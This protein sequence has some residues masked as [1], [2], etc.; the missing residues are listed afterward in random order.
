MHSA[1]GSRAQSKRAEGKL[2]RGKHKLLSNVVMLLLLY[3]R[4]TGT[5]V[6]MYYARSR[7]Y[8]EVLGHDTAFVIAHTYNSKQGRTHREWDSVAQVGRVCEQHKR[9]ADP[10]HSP[11]QNHLTICMET[12]ACKETRRMGGGAPDSQRVCSATPL[13]CALLRL[14]YR[15]LFDETEQHTLPRESNCSTSSEQNI[16]C[17]RVATGRRCSI[18]FARTVGFALP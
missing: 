18:L 6:P 17:A 7:K 9:H 5:S 16:S 2:E 13:F 1:F 8:I 4:C 11:S 10:L 14:A 15:S 3:C 12:L